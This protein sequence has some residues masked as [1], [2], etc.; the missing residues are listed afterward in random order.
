MD[1]M[2]AGRSLALWQAFTDT[3]VAGTGRRLRVHEPRRHSRIAAWPLSQVIWCASAIEALEQAGD[4]ATARRRAGQLSRTP[5]LP[6]RPDADELW[7]AL[8]W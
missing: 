5:Q 3:C 6:I 4:P 8:Q 2:W 7:N 1:A